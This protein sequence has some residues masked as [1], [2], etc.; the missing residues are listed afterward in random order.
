MAITKNYPKLKLEIVVNDI[1][2]EELN[3]EDEQTTPNTVTKYIESCSGSRFVIK[4][5]TYKALA[6][7]RSFASCLP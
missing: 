1:A 7:K 5:H 2:L 4:L 3:D 6:G